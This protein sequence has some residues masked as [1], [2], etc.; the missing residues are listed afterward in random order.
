MENVL[1]L[2]HNNQS[3]ITIPI[4]IVKEWIQKEDVPNVSSDLLLSTET[5]SKNSL[6]TVKIARKQPDD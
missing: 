1:L 6:N 3:L 5:V 4:F 2:Q